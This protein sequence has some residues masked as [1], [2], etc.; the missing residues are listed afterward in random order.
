MLAPL[1]LTVSET[2]NNNFY[3]WHCLQ[4]N[5]DRKAVETQPSNFLIA[6]NEMTFRAFFGSVD[7]IENKDNLTSLFSWEMIPYEYNT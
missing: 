5:E 7:G 1:E 4:G 6:Q 2:L 3:Y